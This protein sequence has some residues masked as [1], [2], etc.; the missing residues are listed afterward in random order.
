MQA[1]IDSYTRFLISKGSSQHTLTAYC[2][3]LA[4]FSGFLVKYFPNG[5]I[6]LSKI[7]RLFLRDFLRWLKNEGRSNRTLARKAATLKNFFKFCLNQG[8]ITKDPAQYLK[9][10][11]YEKKLPMFFTEQE[12]LDILRIPDLNTIAGIRDRAIL[13]LMYSCG[14]RISEVVSLKINNLDF[15]NRIIKVMGKGKKERII[16]FGKECRKALKQYA[17]VRPDFLPDPKEKTFFLNKKGLPLST[18]DT[19]YALDRYLHLVAQTKGYTPHSIRHA[20]ATH[21][22][23]HGADLKGVQEMLGHENLS[24]TEIYTHLSLEE[25]KKVY[26]Q[27]HPRSLEKPKRK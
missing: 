10:P 21:L 19:R 15:H 24:T 16:P 14:L 6:D 26:R 3:D 9:I 12:M 8:Y 27:A 20:F 23:E 11:K 25:V 22:L 4:Q 13:E 2:G 7:E 17:K 1:E 18:N 5:I